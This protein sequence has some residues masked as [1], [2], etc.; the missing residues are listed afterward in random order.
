MNHYIGI[1]KLLRVPLQLP[2]GST[3]SK[4]GW[5]MSIHKVWSWIFH[6]RTS[7]WS[8]KSGHQ[9][10]VLVNIF[11]SILLGFSD[12]LYFSI[13]PKWGVSWVPSAVK[14]PFPLKEKT[15]TSSVDSSHAPCPHLSWLPSSCVSDLLWNHSRLRWSKNPPETTTDADESLQLGK[16]PK[17][18]L[19][20]WKNGWFFVCFGGILNYIPRMCNLQWK[21]IK[22][23]QDA[24]SSKYWCILYTHNNML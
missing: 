15:S 18:D 14:P 23:H 17:S 16:R 10:E 5:S 11:P 8:T 3:G 24:Y 4:E 7:G 1:T 9:P 13:T 19:K 22:M 20:I 21:S 12:S 6:N 2:L